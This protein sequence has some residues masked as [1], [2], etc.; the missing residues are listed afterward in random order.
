[1]HDTICY[2]GV[3]FPPSGECCA[4]VQTTDELLDPLIPR[5]RRRAARLVREKQMEPDDA[6]AFLDLTTAYMHTQVFIQSKGN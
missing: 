1:M 2:I 5:L 6:R 4:E 3:P